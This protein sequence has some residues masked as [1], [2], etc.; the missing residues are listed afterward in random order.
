M[1]EENCGCLDF[2][3][4]DL[5]LS[6]KLRSMKF[7]LCRDKCQGTWRWC[8][9]SVIRLA[10][11]AVIVPDSALVCGVFPWSV[12]APAGCDRGHSAVGTGRA[13]N[14][15]LLQ[16]DSRWEEDQVPEVTA[17]SLRVRSGGVI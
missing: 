4:G 8:F 7:G 6:L 14:Q 9:H 1:S 3:F 11:G 15:E 10:P 13:Q 5:R 2:S 17:L 16:R 12:L